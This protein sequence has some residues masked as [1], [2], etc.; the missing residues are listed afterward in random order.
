MTDAE[1]SAAIALLSATSAKREK[2]KGMRV[3]ACL[4]LSLSFS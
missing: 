1:L 4:W 3:D 2:E